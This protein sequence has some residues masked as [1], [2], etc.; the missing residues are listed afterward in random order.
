MNTNLNKI[1]LNNKASELYL[2]NKEY[3]IHETIK[4]GN[5]NQL[6]LIGDNTVITSGKLLK[7]WYEKDGLFLYDA[8]DEK[9][10]NQLYKNG[11]LLERPHT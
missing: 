2:D 6:K 9:Y 7:Q 10:S 4:L 1:I 8:K 11:K 3:F 5:I